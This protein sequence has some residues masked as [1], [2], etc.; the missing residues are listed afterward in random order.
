MTRKAILVAA[1][2][3]LALGSSAALAAGKKHANGAST[4]ADPRMEV[5]SKQKGGWQGWCNLSSSC[6]GWDEYFK[7]VAAHK[8]YA[9]TPIVIPKV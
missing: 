3:A 6:N 5:Q 9:P 8:K 1:S 4:G 7:G 2:I